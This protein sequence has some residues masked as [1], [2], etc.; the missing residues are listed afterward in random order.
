VWLHSLGFDPERVADAPGLV[1]ARTVAM[2]V[3]E[4]ADAVLQGVCNGR[5]FV[6]QL[7][8]HLPKHPMA[9]QITQYGAQLRFMVVN[10]RVA[11]LQSLM[12]KKLPLDLSRFVLSPMPG[13][14]TQ[15]L[16]QAGQ[17]VLAGERLAVIEAMKMENVLVASQDAV[18][19]SIQVK[20]GDTLAVDQIMVEFL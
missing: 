4:A 20:V 11:E 6:A 15:V 9:M 2:L 19:K 3:N 13:L 10:P 8:R 16:V 18:V 17:K 14:L 1:V 12:P 5:P 7:E